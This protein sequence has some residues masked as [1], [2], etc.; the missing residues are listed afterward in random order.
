MEIINNINYAGY[1]V[2][3]QN[4]NGRRKYLCTL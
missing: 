1:C 3:L 4:F 2:M